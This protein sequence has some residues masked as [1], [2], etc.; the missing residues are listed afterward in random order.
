MFLRN[1]GANQYDLPVFYENGVSNPFM[2]CPPNDSTQHYIP[3]FTFTNQ[4]GEAVGRTE[5]E[6]KI[7]I[8]DF[9]F[10]SCP[11][12]CPIMSKEMERVN[13][14]FRDEPAVQ[15]MSISIDPT[16]DTPEVLKEYA[17]KHGAIP[18]K[19][20]FLTGPPE[21][22][23]QLAKCGFVLPTVDGMGNPDDFVHSD[24]FALI[25]EQ[26]RIRGYY[27]GTNR[28]DVDLLILETKV[29]LHG[30]S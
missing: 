21:E 13:D 4:D 10:T 17:D 2:E 8:V 25:D 29:L 14:M 30:K 3:E 27:S 12:I 23:Y 7:T 5:M 20:H 19:W 18:G 26:G 11:S 15:I 1:F 22:T 6:G 28:E 9:F 24:K 16:Y